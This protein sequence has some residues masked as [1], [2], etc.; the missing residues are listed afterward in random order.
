MEIYVLM[1]VVAYLLIMSLVGYI[2]MAWDKKKAIRDVRRIPEKTLLTIAAVGGALG[3][4]IGMR[5]YRHKTKHFKFVFLVP[6][7]LLLHIAI[8]AL[9]VWLL[10]F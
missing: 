5:V 7:C 8:L 3:S 4:F 6:L 2:S 9:L 1:G 10:F